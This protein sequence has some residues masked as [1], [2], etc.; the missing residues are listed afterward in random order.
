M[1]TIGYTEVAERYASVMAGPRLTFS[2]ES[3]TSQPVDGSNPMLRD[4]SPFT[5]FLLPPGG[6]TVASDHVH[7]YEITIDNETGTR[8]GKV[9]SEDFN[10]FHPEVYTGATSGSA[11][12]GAASQTAGNTIRGTFGLNLVEP[13]TISSMDLTISQLQQAVSFG[14]EIKTTGQGEFI[15]PTLADEYTVA[16]IL[17]QIAQLLNIPPLTLLINPSEMT[18][19]YNQIQ[20]FTDRGREGFIFQ[21][22]GEQ[23]PTISFQG[24]TGAFMAAEPTSAGVAPE[25]IGQAWDAFVRGTNASSEIG[26]QDGYTD[27]ATGVQFASMRDS[28]AYQNFVALYHFYRNNGLIYDTIEESEAHLFVG[29]VAIVYDQVVYVGHMSSFEVNF[30]DEKQHSIDFNIEF[31]VDQMYDAA[32]APS[33][34][35]PMEAPSQANDYPGRSNTSNSNPTS[36]SDAVLSTNG[37]E[38][39]AVTGGADSFVDN[40]TYD[41]SSL[42]SNCDS[43][44]GDL[45]D[46]V[47]LGDLPNTEW[48]TVAYESG[49]S[50]VQQ[51]D[52]EAVQDWLDSLRDV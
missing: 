47:G 14:K 25:K 28:A 17:L 52:K 40:S 24:S 30:T 2:F 42:D 36:A 41:P 5:L 32:T 50:Y 49:T 16:D 6:E 46:A 4:L 3:Q 13:S 45:Y 11:A 38:W 39:L 10:S 27:N 20:N 43:N 44:Y 1:A 7:Q 26:G 21:R 48:P 51:E 33:V 8:D 31:V 35:L 34:V 9:T 23:Q 18:T 12:P 22:W 37:V 15:Y 19:N 29:A